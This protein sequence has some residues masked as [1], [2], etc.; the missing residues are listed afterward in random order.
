[1]SSGLGQSGAMTLVRGRRIC[2]F[3][4]KPYTSGEI[5]NKVKACLA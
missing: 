5:G 1:M 2:G 4:Q 3:I